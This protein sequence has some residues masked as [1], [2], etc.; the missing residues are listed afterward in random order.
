[1]QFDGIPAMF[2]RRAIYTDERVISRQNVLGVLNQAMIVHS[3]NRAEI[4]FLYDYYRGDQPVLHRKKEI[5]A[6]INN[7]IV[8]NHAN[9]IVSFKVGYLMGEPVQYVSRDADDS[10]DAEALNKLNRYMYANNK[11]ALDKE[12][13]DWF[14]I[15]GVAY[16]MVLPSNDSEIDDAPFTLYTLNPMRTFVVFWSGLGNEPVM[17][18]YVVSRQNGSELY[19]VYTK[20]RYFE[21]ENG[22]IV[23]ET[24][25]SLGAVPIVEYE[26]NMA[27]QGAFEIVLPM[28]D[29][30]N[31]IASNRADGLEQFVQALLVLKNVDVDGDQYK[32]LLRQGGLLVPSDGDAKYLTQELNQTQTQTLVDYMYQTVLTICG[33]PSTSGGNTSDSSNNGAVILKNGW[34]SAEARAKDTELLF[35]K[36][37]RRFLKIAMNIAN[38][39]A[40]DDF[41]AS[42]IEIR[43]TRRNYENLQ[44]K[45]QVLLQMLSS[46]KIHP[47][48]AFA[49]C[50]MFADPE[51]AYTASMEYEKQRQAEAEAEL[52]EYRKQVGQSSEQSTSVEEIVTERDDGGGGD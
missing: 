44:E 21:I 11:A 19:C 41:S 18:V 46:D 22:S 10:A 29:A 43:F 49:H 47:R 45:A 48:L 36:S 34:Q 40:D 1:M 3:Q 28:L 31:T 42:S 38:I 7:R 32:E 50:G 52:E 33:M 26:A 35:K 14:S 30:I 27:R 8:E 5:R 15:C 23:S 12:L 37:E 24:P 9:E 4:A 17:G 25:H 20:D 16:R 39:V 2:G 6:E 13:A 51:V